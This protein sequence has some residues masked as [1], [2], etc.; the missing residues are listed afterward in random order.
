MINRSAPDCGCS[1]TSTIK[2][3][4]FDSITIPQLLCPHIVER[5][6]RFLTL[7]T[8][9]DKIIS[10]Q[11]LFTRLSWGHWLYHTVLISRCSMFSCQS[12]SRTSYVDKK[13]KVELERTA[14]KSSKLKQP[15]SCIKRTTQA[16]YSCS[17]I[18][19]TKSLEAKLQSCVN[20][21]C[22][23]FSYASSFL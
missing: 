8:T 12:T 2:V 23:C 18:C 11:V 16:F 10:A 3:I 21:N 9:A 14:N 7:E 5:D 20:T 1:Y 17:P 22:F 19:K 13:K 15:F 4:L 6:S